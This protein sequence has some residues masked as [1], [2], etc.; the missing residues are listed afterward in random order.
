MVRF[1]TRLGDVDFDITTL[2]MVRKSVKSLTEIIPI[3][4][5][6]TMLITGISEQ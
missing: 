5:N 2:V 1:S 6:V 3:G 4:L